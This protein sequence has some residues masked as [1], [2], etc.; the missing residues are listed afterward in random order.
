MPRNKKKNWW[1]PEMINQ[2][3]H[4]EAAGSQT[5]ERA[6]AVALREP[7][8]GVGVPPTTG[9]NQ[10]FLHQKTNNSME[11]DPNEAKSRLQALLWGRC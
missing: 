2:V 4:R 1:T 3:A 7:P 5:A 10:A 11:T 8:K 9:A 6:S